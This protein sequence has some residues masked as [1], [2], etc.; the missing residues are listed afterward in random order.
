M[1]TLDAQPSKTSNLRV[2]ISYSW[3]SA[4]HKAWVAK[5][6]QDLEGI[7]ELSVTW[8]GF[9]LDE[10]SDKDYFMESGLHES[11]YVLIVATRRYAEKA[12]ERSGGVGIETSLAVS[13]HFEQFEKSHRSKIVVLRR[14]PESTPR[15][16]Q[17]KLFVDFTETENYDTGIA[18]LLDIFRGE[19]RVARPPKRLHLDSQ[20]RSYTFTRVEDV[21]RI[22]HKNR[23]V[24]ISNAEGTDFSGAN[25]I[26]FELWE[27]RSPNVG[28]FLALFENI[29]LVQT[30]ARVAETLKAKDIRTAAITILRPTS[31]EP[32][33]LQRYFDQAGYSVSV[34]EFTYADYLWSY[35]IDDQLKCASVPDRAS[36]YTDQAVRLA[37]TDETQQSARKFFENELSAV[38]TPTARVLIAPGGMGKTSLCWAMVY[39]LS[40]RK[41]QHRSVVFIQA[42]SLRNYFASEGIANIH[43]RTVYE[44]Y[45][46]YSKAQ[47]QTNVYDVTTFDLAVLCGNIVVIID[48]LDELVSL[49]Q[50]RFELDRFLASIQMLHNELGSSNV[51]I[52]TRDGPLLDES[53]L[54]ELGMVRYYLLGFD[55]ANCA[56]YA[57]RRFRNTSSQAELSKL[58]TERL[59]NMKLL[60]AA[61]RV[62]PFF[63]DI[64]ATILEEEASSVS[65]NTFDVSVQQTPYPS[66]NDL[67]D[68]II[69]AVL[70]REELRHGLDITVR[71]IASFISELVVEYGEQI[72][73]AEILDR[74]RLV[75]DERGLDLFS[76]LSLN[77]LFTRK[78]GVLALRYSFLTD[79]FSVLFLID[80][81]IQKSTTREFRK[82]LQRLNAP[83]S[84]AFRDISRFFSQYEGKFQALAR[85]ALLNL[86]SHATRESTESS[87]EVLSREDA[88]RGISAVL[89]LY[90]KVTGASGAQ[91]TQKLL[92][93]Y[94]C[95]ENDDGNVTVDGLFVYGDFPP[96]DF[97]E[98][99]IVGSRF[100]GYTNFAK[101]K[102]ANS[103]FM[104]TVFERCG[105]T[106]HAEQSLSTAVFDSSCDL[107][108]LSE[109]LQRM[110]GG[111]EA[112][113][114]LIEGDVRKFFHCF[115][116]GDHF[117]DVKTEHMKFSS[118]LSRL[119]LDDFD[120]LVRHGYL[121]V[122]SQKQKETFYVL[123][124][125]L[126]P[127]VN[128]FLA[129][130]YVD[131][132]IR[133][134]IELVR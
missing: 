128:R 78:E 85:A 17:G 120:R 113:N 73:S 110:S 30:I 38:Q 82:S 70:R 103:R 126:K 114:A 31:G 89:R 2:F 15:Y 131:Q 19:S 123:A 74:L 52:T 116:K 54:E 134:F 29:T 8:D 12:N 87:K 95:R 104:Y 62:V 129:N 1:S 4:E 117:I 53:R 105:G 72:P 3:D 106:C 49:L 121:K 56:R 122:K 24:V 101:C 93:L 43:I 34:H 44:L 33:L 9:D 45:E 79:Y 119:S 14:E 102:F 66:N 18:R 125:A 112:E 67:V 6:A 46:F 48:G 39:D 47:G 32:G 127:S 26:K 21:I 63:V 124:D 64:L 55:E 76:K 25:K 50:E 69:Y 130:N 41:S 96:I 27:T 13:R 35:C 77:P 81:F 84:T 83:E 57:Q 10:T 118:R 23:R 90:V 109:T 59:Q 36:N 100:S 16:L 99:T 22:N 71:E 75:Y 80:Q 111:R 37:T 42:E 5:L 108:D 94:D 68:H 92:E 107:G 115:F 88:R 60:Y 40:T 133:D 7:H 65:A 51:L 98:L 91:L 11:D 86:K 28:Y 58:F 20:S 132:K 97:S 61:G